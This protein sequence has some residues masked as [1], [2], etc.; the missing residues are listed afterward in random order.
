MCC[1]GLITKKTLSNTRHTVQLISQFF[2][3]TLSYNVAVC[4]LP[5]HYSI[6]FRVPLN[7]LV[8]TPDGTRT[9]VW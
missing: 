9:P 3:C 8:R 5:R 6:F 1:N 4:T 7:A 2:T